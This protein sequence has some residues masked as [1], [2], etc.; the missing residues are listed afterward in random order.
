MGWGSGVR[1]FDEI[2]AALLDGKEVSKKDVIKVIA[3]VLEDGDWDTQHCSRYWDHPL[4]REVM[5]ELH[6][7]WFEDEVS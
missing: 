6:P 2:C 7:I 3:S 1:I 5:M 4:V